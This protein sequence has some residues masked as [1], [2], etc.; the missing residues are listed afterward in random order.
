MATLE[1]REN[2]KKVGKKRVVDTDNWKKNVTKRSR[3]GAQRAKGPDTLP[4]C[5]CKCYSTLDS[6]VIQKCFDEY[7]SLLT[8]TEQTLYLRGCVKPRQAERSRSRKDSDTLPVRQV[9][10]FHL[11]QS[12]VTYRVCQA[13]FL[14]VLGIQRSKLQR[15]I[16]GSKRDMAAQDLRGL[17]GNRIN[18]TP[19][20]NLEHVREFLKN[21]P[22][23][24]SHYSR[25]KQSTRHYLDGNLNISELHRQYVAMFPE[26]IVSRAV[27]SQVF[28]YEFN[29]CFAG[30]RSDICE[31]CERF[32]TKIVAAKA[33]HNAT[34]LIDLETQ[35]E[36]H[37][38]KAE[39]FYDE[40][41][42]RHNEDTL[43]ICFDYQ[44]NLPI[45][46]TNVSGE[47]Y[48]R[49]L[50]LHNFGIYNMVSKETQLYVYS[51][52]FAKKGPNE[53]LSCLENYIATRC[54]PN[55]SKLVIFADNCFSQ[56]KNRYMFG[57]LDNLC[58][59]G[60]FSQIEIFYPLPGHS[61]MAIDREFAKIERKKRRMEK[62]N[63]PEDWLTL[64]KNAKIEKPFGINFVQH[65]LR[66][67]L[68]LLDGDALVQVKDFKSA[69]AT[70]L[71]TN[72]AVSQIR[73]AIFRT[74]R[75]AESRTTMKGS[76]SLMTLHKK[77]H[78]RAAALV[79]QACSLAF[80]PVKQAKAIDLRYLLDFVP[81]ENRKCAFYESVSSSV[82]ELQNDSQNDF[83]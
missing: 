60:S 47:Y 67:D 54:A 18:K 77:G 38:R 15:K 41:R 76:T 64:I 53:V 45:P 33:D 83:E 24:E 36:L 31:T 1:S 3:R 22:K 11:S 35:K 51:E 71:K 79:L 20:L 63:S 48:R 55:Q 12:G 44:K 58:A 69:M 21:Y 50:W 52:H 74:N 49:Q 8:T 23:R 43:V 70:C 61:M 4:R 19:E 14:A 68:K 40:M 25:T 42:K 17:H 59:R 28:S 75:P 9:Y 10:D 6:G 72:I 65:P 81:E 73:A 29:I 37:L 66:S 16:V 34:A 78:S 32:R 30:P 80:V 26:N 46:V 27:F 39:V 62:F 82:S 2:V 7:H 56:N 57:F 5:R 13:T